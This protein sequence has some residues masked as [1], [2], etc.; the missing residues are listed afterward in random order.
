MTS[1][2]ATDVIITKNR[3]ASRQMRNETFIIT[4]TK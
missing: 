2:T 3:P 4:T 1:D